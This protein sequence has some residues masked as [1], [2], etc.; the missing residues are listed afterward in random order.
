MEEF[1]KSEERV[2]ETCHR[3]WT[4]VNRW[5][6]PPKN[7]TGLI[8]GVGAGF[9]T[10]RQ[11]RTV[12][13]DGNVTLHHKDVVLEPRI[14]SYDQE[15]LQEWSLMEVPNSGYFQIRN[16][17]GYYLSCGTGGNMTLEG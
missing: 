7:Q 4:K 5:V 8:E 16:A 12:D 3:G 1:E 9:L 13:N 10:L 6:L 11:L 15:Y 2:V 17:S 14:T